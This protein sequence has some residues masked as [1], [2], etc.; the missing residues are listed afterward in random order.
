MLIKDVC[1]ECSLTK[2]AVEYYEKQ[3]LLQPEVGENGYRNYSTEDIAMLREISVL[4]KL[5]IGTRDIG[6]ILSSKNKPAVLARCELL[7]DIRLQ[8]MTEKQRGIRMLMDEY[9]IDTAMEFLQSHLDLS[10]TIKEKL[11]QAF[12]GPYGLYLSIHFGPFLNE[13]PDSPEKEESLDKIIRYLDDVDLNDIP[14]ELEGFLENCFDS[15]EKNALQS[16]DMI[17]AAEDIEGFIEN[18]SE[19]IEVYLKM[20][21]SEEYK[22]TPVCRMRHML[23]DFLKSNGYY[24]VFVA[25]MKILSESYRRYTEKLDASNEI[26]MK[27]YPQA[28]DL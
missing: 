9:D 25:N 10:L 4:R 3:G 13:K 6:S 1:R 22:E 28:R 26:L 7:A 23:L 12:P 2:K 18:N 16:I 27:R 15:M 11:I 19:T 5:G 20:R 24:D 14:D 8:R 21:L 17:N